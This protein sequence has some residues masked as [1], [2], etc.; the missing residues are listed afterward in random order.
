MKNLDD[1]VN[2]KKYDYHCVIPP[3]N[4]QIIRQALEAYKDNDD[5][6][7]NEG[8]GKPDIKGIDDT[9]ELLNKSKIE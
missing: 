4:M 6:K 8:N 9:L 2:E 1:F 5:R 3:F 7:K